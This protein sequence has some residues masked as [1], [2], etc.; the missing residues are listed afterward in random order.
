MQPNEI[1]VA[2]G[3]Q[4]P[5]LDLVYDYY[6]CG[7]NNGNVCQVTNTKD[8]ARSQ[9]FAYDYLNR[10][11]WAWTPNLNSSGAHNWGEGFSYDPWGNLLQKNTMGSD[12]PPD[13]SL[14]VTV[15]TKNQ[16]TNW[17]YDAAGNIIDPTRPCPA[18]PPAGYP[19]VYDGQNRLTAA[20]VGAST[21]SY[22]Y[23]ADGQRAKKTGSTNTLYWYGP[24]G[25]LEETDLNGVLKNEYVFFGGKRAARYNPANGYSYYFSD[26]LGSADVVTDALGNIKEES[27]FY[28]FGGERVVTD[29]GIG[30]NYK[31]TGKERDPETGCDFFGARYYCNPTGRFLTPDWAAKPVTV[32]Y[33]NF[34][35]PQ[36]LNL[37]SYVENNPTTMGDPDGHCP[38]CYPTDGADWVDSKVQAAREYYAPNLG[39]DGP[40]MAFTKTFFSGVAGDVTSGFANGLRLGNGTAA[41]IDEAKQG[42]YLGAASDLS[43]D[44]G[45]V[46][47]VILT[48]VAVGGPKT[49]ATAENGAQVASEVGKNRVALDNGS[50]VDLAG[51]AHF[52][53]S[54][55][56]SVATPH[57]KDPVY[58]TNPNTGVTYQNGYGPVRPATV[59]DVNAAARTAGATPPVRTPPPPPVPQPKKDE[60]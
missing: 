59:G 32:P 44:G 47:Q 56:E 11:V 19:N 9:A 52:E 50:Q 17:C 54:T 26:Q 60:K 2:A 34:G 58:N 37:Y 40:A 49:P 25:V 57:I 43:Q 28:P 48:V 36:S 6:S 1:H 42:D 45:R 31:F 13:T 33:A 23:D 16:A 22:D 10:L 29:S 30:N 27:D 39:K 35:N 15:N 24:G 38:P 8:S 14:N 12:N 7:G 53:K 20:T 21:T 55:G 3:T 41:A 51:K 4:P 5:L 46:G 18:T